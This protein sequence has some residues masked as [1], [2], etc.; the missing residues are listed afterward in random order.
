MGVRGLDVAWGLAKGDNGNL[1][2]RVKGDENDSQGAK[3]CVGH[4]NK[5]I[6]AEFKL[7]FDF[8]LRAF[9]L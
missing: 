6:G 2:D 1:Y 4:Y 5:V 3:F 7:I 9:T 8:M